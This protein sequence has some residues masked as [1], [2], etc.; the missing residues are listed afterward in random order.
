MAPARRVLPRIH[1]ATHMS[2]NGRS[3]GRTLHC[4]KVGLFFSS[5]QVF[6]QSVALTPPGRWTEHSVTANK[7]PDQL[8]L[9]NGDGAVGDPASELF[10]FN[11]LLP[12]ITHKCGSACAH[13]L[14]IGA[15]VLLRNW[16][17]PYN[18]TSLYAIS[19]FEQLYY[20]LHG[21]PRA[22]N[23]AISQRQSQVQLWSDFIYMA[24]PFIAYYGALQCGP[25]G[26]ALLQTA[27]EQVRLYRQVL[28]DKDVGLWRHIA[29]GNGTDPT[30]WATGNAWAAAGTLRVLATIR[31][32]GAGWSMRSQ[33]NNLIRWVGETLDGVWK[34]QVGI[35]FCRSAFPFS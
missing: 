1:A 16:T 18:G 34:H 24:P 9:I 26:D 13:I 29:L 17:L 3:G 15:S 5:L 30:H 12:P 7:P 10:I 6:P 21:A 19:A 32:S 28:F 11:F 20:L 22:P 33:Q 8:P 23:G 4:R 2:R 31:H 35:F 14:G 27:Y 25:E